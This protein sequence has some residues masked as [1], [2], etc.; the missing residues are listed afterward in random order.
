MKRHKKGPMDRHVVASPSSQ[1]KLVG[2]IDGLFGAYQGRSYQIMTGMSCVIGRD[3]NC[4]IQINHNRVSRVHC[5]VQFLP[6]GMY[7]IIDC[8]SNGTYYNNVRLEKNKTYTLPKGALVVLG[9]PDN[10]IQ[11]N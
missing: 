6:N 1:P 11:L 5:K 2:Q 8:S 3:A 4:D 9:N 10:V 7:Q